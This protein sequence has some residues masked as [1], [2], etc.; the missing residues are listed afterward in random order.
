MGD[1]DFE[2]L[3]ASFGVKTEVIEIL[4]SS[5]P[6]RD[7]FD[8]IVSAD[9]P[10]DFWE[11]ID[12]LPRHVSMRLHACQ[13]RIDTTSKDF[14]AETLSPVLELFW[15]AHLQSQNKTPATINAKSITQV[16]PDHIVRFVAELGGWQRT[17][18]REFQFGDFAFSVDSL[19]AM[20]D[21]FLSSGAPWVFCEIADLR[22]AY[23]ALAAQA[24]KFGDRLAYLHARVFV[25]LR[26]FG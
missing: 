22:R 4:F 11:H 13:A 1:D 16:T 17:S 14:P 9:S 19:I 6:F 7:M 15:A 12:S 24:R 18:E 5:I 23:F 2:T 10:D 21:T 20:C 3:A 25:K 8:C 26:S